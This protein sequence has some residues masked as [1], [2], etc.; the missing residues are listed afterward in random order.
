VNITNLFGIPDGF[1]NISPNRTSIVFDTNRMFTP[2]EPWNYGFLFLTNR[3]GSETVGLTQGLSSTWSPDGH[4]VA[5]QRSASGFGLP[6]NNDVFSPPTTDSD[7]FT[8]NVDDLL[9]GAP[10]TN[11]TN[12]PDIIDEDPDWSPD[13]TKIAFTRRNAGPWFAR[14]PS[15][16]IWVMAPDGSH[17]IQLTHNSTAES[18]PAWSPDGSLITY[19]CDTSTGGTDNVW[20]ICVMNADGS[21]Q[22]Q[23]TF[24]LLNGTPSFS[25][26]G[27]QIIFNKVDFSTFTYQLFT[28]NLDGTNRHEL[29]HDHCHNVTARWQPLKV[30]V[31]N[32]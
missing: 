17:Q 1:P 30:N 5:F 21:N 18:A 27:T 7:I 12:S 13:G 11:I 22:H 9:A 23:I 20:N 32:N 3:D 26:D 8:G 6:V 15:V 31:P 24:D 4:S 28:I 25:P 19:M 29:T 2:S 16:E 10:P 14:D